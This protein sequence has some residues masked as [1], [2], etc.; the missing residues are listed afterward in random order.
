MFN[1]FI[2]ELNVKIEGD[3]GLV[4]PNDHNHRVQRPK[5]SPIPTH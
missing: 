3:E 4:K 1:V 5:C 2:F